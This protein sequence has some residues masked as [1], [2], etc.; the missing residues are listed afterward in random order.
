MTAAPMPLVIA[1]DGPS[2]SGKSSVSKAVA[3]RLD[4]AYLDTGAMY[5]ALTWWCFQQGVDL[6]DQPAVARAAKDLPLRMGTDPNS[7]WVRV[8]G[9][10]IDQAIRAT[11]ISE[12]VSRVA[13]NLG[14]RAELCDRQRALIA[15]SV[16]RTGGVVA[17]GRDITTVVAPDAHVRILLLANQKA[18]LARR[19]RELHG[20]AD[21]AAVN[22]TRD[23]IV[24]RDEDDSTVSQFMQ[25]APGVTAVDTSDMSFEQSVDA[26]LDVVRTRS[27]REHG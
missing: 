20:E 18:R 6:E 11:V 26:V 7:P 15:E 17:E 25:P 23:Q 8:G 10:V 21:H 14:V 24:R 22:A 1:I 19:A 3:Q 2:G 9:V 13:I 16:H 4:V 27:L 12:S 5:R